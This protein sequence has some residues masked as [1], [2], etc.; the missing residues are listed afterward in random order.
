MANLKRQNNQK[1]ISEFKD[2]RG[3]D[4]SKKDLKIVPTEILITTN[5]DTK[6]I[7]P[8]RD[9]LPINFN[10]E[11]IIMEAK[12]PGLG[13]KELHKRGINGHGVKV[14]I[15]DQTL[16]SEN[17]VIMP[18]VEYFSRIVDYKEYGGA[19]KE[20]ISM[21][22]PAVTSLLV[23]KTCGVAPEVDLIYRSTP[24]G[25]NFN[26]K[27][28]ALLNIIEFN[29]TLSS[30]NK[31][32][33][34]SCSIGYMEKNSEIG[35]RRWIGTIKYAENENILIVDVGKRTGVNYIG[36]GAGGDK[37]DINNYDV[38]LFFSS[39]YKNKEVNKIKEEIIIPSDY[40]TMA[41]N[42]GYREYVYNGKGGMSWSVPYLT[43]LFALAF[44]IN[45]NLTKKKIADAINKTVSINKKGFKIINP[46]GFIKSVQK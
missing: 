36:G 32:R 7:W 4:L 44:Q 39:D 5:F 45:P 33:I 3:L 31:I 15:I 21:H 28:D 13:I 42:A 18:H 10:P 19:D 12:N 38:A 43:G 17:G 6:T 29:K 20:Q 26:Y 9:K 22:G 37:N 8:K 24:S 11:K 25:R 14:A 40:R 35:L 41:S 34:V 23:G 27:A 46:I 16:S 1:I 2:L 30:K